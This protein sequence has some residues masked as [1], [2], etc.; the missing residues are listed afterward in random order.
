MYCDSP[1]TRKEVGWLFRAHH[2]HAVKSII[3]YSLTT[4]LF[5]FHQRCYRRNSLTIHYLSL[6]FVLFTGITGQKRAKLI[7]LLKNEVASS[8]Y[9]SSSNINYHLHLCKLRTIVNNFEKAENTK[10]RSRVK[11][12]VL[13]SECINICWKEQNYI[14]L[15]TGCEGF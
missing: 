7:L 9:D 8:I 15:W 14:K 4:C 3:E 1:F 11:N 12:Y 5:A 6:F 2:H 13:W 10:W